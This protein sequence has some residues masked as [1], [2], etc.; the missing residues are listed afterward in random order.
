MLLAGKKPCALEQLP[1]NSVKSDGMSDGPHKAFKCAHE[2]QETEQ[3]TKSFDKKAAKLEKGRRLFEKLRAAKHKK[4]ASSSG[5]HLSP[6]EFHKDSGFSRV[7]S[8]SGSGLSRVSSGSGNVSGSNESVKS[9]SG[10][11]SNYSEWEIRN[12]LKSP[13][14]GGNGGAAAAANQTTRAPDAPD[15]VSVLTGA[16][17]LFLFQHFAPEVTKIATP[18]LATHIEKVSQE[19]GLAFGSEQ[20]SPQLKVPKLW[21]PGATP[22]DSLEDEDQVSPDSFEDKDQVSQVHDD[23]ASPPGEPACVKQEIVPIGVFSKRNRFS[24]FPQ[25]ILVTPQATKA[26]LAAVSAAKHL[27]NNWHYSPNGKDDS[28]DTIHDENIAQKIGGRVLDAEN[29]LAFACS[30]YSSEKSGTFDLFA[31]GYGRGSEGRERHEKGADT[32]AGKAG[33]DTE[34]ELEEG[35]RKG[36]DKGVET[37]LNKAAVD[38]VFAKD[39]QSHGVQWRLPEVIR[40]AVIELELVEQQETLFQ[41]QMGGVLGLLGEREAHAARLQAELVSQIATHAQERRELQSSWQQQVAC[42]L[43][44]RMCFIRP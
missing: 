5:G 22:R 21:A 20:S 9:G 14:S 2:T 4:P 15:V 26:A 11:E 33:A 34:G 13:G 41:E 18:K 16:A 39:K 30:P 42:C 1:Y 24:N 43:F 40:R 3:D 7:S 23:Q 25:P 10:S 28:K 32:E 37:E 17:K 31:V 29:P 44:K 8:G 35:L 12:E 19:N 36:P 6:D 38:S 27:L